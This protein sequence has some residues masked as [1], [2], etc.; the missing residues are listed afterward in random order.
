MHM[1]GR[2]TAVRFRP[3]AWAVVVLWLAAPARAPADEDVLARCGDALIRRGDLT[4][5]IQRLGMAEM[6]PGPRRQRAEAAI[7]EQLVDERILRIELDRVGVAATE[8]E[9]D[10]AVER[11]RE[12]VAGRGQDF[13]ATLLA[14]GR[15]QAQLREQLALEIR[16]DKFVRPQITPE[17]IA[18]VFE[19]NRRELDGTKLRVSQILLR[20]DIAGEGDPTAK[21]LEQAGEIRSRVIQGRLSFAAAAARHSAGPSR[22]RGGDLGWIERD[23]PMVEAFSNQ[24]FRLAK[25]GVSPPFVTPFG[26]HVVTVTAVEPGRK[27]LDAVRARIEKLLASQLVRGLVIAGRQRTAVVF[28]PDVPHFDPATIDRPADE[29][30]VV[31]AAEPAE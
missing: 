9:V 12:Q 3:S 22:R 17:A 19:Q 24:A 6:P 20:P 29:R 23:G 13:D 25:G 21:L 7:L 16:L 18:A 1:T 11:L 31:V 27:G 5:V 4:A 10:A 2:R 8:A 28:E 15:S 14:S 30:R 26:V